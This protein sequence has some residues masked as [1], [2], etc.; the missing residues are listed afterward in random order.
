MTITFE[1]ARPEDEPIIRDLQAE[2]VG[3]LARKGTDQWQPSAMIA[4][5]AGSRDVRR[6][7]DEMARGEVFLVKD[8]TTVVGTVTLD[9]HADPEFWTDEDE[10]KSALYMHRMVVSRDAAGRGLGAAMLAWAADQAARSGKTWL[11]LDAWR[12]NTHLHDY[13][14]RHGFA[15][16]RTIDLPWR[17]SG[18]LFQRPV[19]PVDQHDDQ[20]AASPT[21]E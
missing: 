2:A 8:G 10:P 4:R 5:T 12:T 14:R 18:A 3:W 16:V 11:P 13:Y 9:E 6:L 7:R 19:R 20:S 21:A 15:H 1:Q 17:G